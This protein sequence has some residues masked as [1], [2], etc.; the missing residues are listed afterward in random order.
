M[1]EE[2]K[3]D[4]KL[5][6]AFHLMFDHY[7]EPVQLAH[8]SKRIMA[9]NPASRT[10]GRE[11]GMICAQHGTPEA[12][13]GCLAVQAVKEGQ[14]KWRTAE[15]AGPGGRQAVVF[16]LPVTGFPD[17]YIHFSAGMSKDYAATQS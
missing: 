14:A 7:P 6:E 13:K 8:K 4:E 12:H 17:F 10:I 5:I 11:V 2:I 3:A 16:W 15:P 1:S 9:L